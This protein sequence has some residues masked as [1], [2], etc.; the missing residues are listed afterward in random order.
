MDLPKKHEQQQHDAIGEAL[1]ELMC[2]EESSIKAYDGI[3]KAIDSWL[4][5]HQ[6][7]L[8]K[9]KELKLLVNGK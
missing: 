4:S 2:N 5:Y 6:T 3:V 1:Q 9:W 8:K 7:E